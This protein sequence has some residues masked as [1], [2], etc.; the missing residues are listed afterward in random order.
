MTSGELVE[1]LSRGDRLA[2]V[3]PGFEV[4]EEQ[5]R[6]AHAI[7][8]AFDE[9]HVLLAE[10]GTGVGKSFAYLLAAMDRAETQGERVVVST[11]TIALQEQLLNKDIPLLLPLTA[12]HSSGMGSAY[13]ASGS[14]GS[15][16]E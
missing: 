4:R 5:V 8:T 7:A 11:H 15:W 6:L 1:F 9:R 13:P 16:T 3:L 2:E 10:A 12:G 14:R